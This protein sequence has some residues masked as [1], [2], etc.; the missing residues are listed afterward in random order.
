MAKTATGVKPA[1]DS[2]RFKLFGET[3]GAVRYQEVDS[4]GK[5][6]DADKARI[7]SLY[8]RKSQFAKISGDYASSGKPSEFV[9]VQV[10]SE[11]K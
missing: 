3:K 10:T 11:D 9:S 2:I 5:D 8:F 7:G 6:V 1:N 4:D